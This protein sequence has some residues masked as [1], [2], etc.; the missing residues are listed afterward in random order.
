MSAVTAITCQRQPPLL[1]FCFQYSG[2]SSFHNLIQTMRGS[3]A[4]W[5]RDFQDRLMVGDADRGLTE[6]AF[7]LS[8]KLSTQPTGIKYFLCVRVFWK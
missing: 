1:T 3:R 4:V 7:V 8:A 6:T 2:K 5:S